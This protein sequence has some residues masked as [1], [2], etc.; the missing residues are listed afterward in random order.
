MPEDLAVASKPDRDQEF[1]P[2]GVSEA[3]MAA[4]V[5]K[6]VGKRWVWQPRTFLY[7]LGTQVGRSQRIYANAAFK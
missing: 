6:G 2:T 1:P 7:R 4:F 3:G 5:Q